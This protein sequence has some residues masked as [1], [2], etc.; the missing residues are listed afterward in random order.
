MVFVRFILSVE[1]RTTLL[2][3]AGSI[4]TLSKIEKINQ[5]LFPIYKYSISPLLFILRLNHKPTI[6]KNL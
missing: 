6:K 1:K 5:C 3:R 4:L 2:L